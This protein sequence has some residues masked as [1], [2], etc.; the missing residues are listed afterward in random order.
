MTDAMEYLKRKLDAMSAS[1]SYA[2]VPDSDYLDVITEMYH[3]L[4]YAQERIVQLEA[5][6][7][8]LPRNYA[9]GGGETL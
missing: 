2:E 8:R 4:K 3:Q 9:F 6:V 7:A 5:D 1:G